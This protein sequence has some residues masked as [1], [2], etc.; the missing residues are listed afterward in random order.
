[1]KLTELSQRAYVPYSGKPEACV[2][3]SVEGEFFGGVRI[4]NVSFPLTIGAVQGAICHCLLAGQVPKTVFIEHD[5]YVP[6]F[7]REEFELEIQEADTEHSFS[8]YS[9][10]KTENVDI[11]QCLKEALPLAVVPNSEFRVSSYLES[12]EGYLVGANVEFSDWA[13]GLCAERLAISMAVTEGI[14]TFDRMELHT[15]KGNFSSPCGACRQVIYEFMPLHPIQFHH[16]DGTKSMHQ[17]VDLLPY[18]FRSN[19]LRKQI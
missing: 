10:L 16:A 7:F 1:M 17:T 13:H 12:P 9:Y 2:I 3:E 8:L 19:E 11:E 5:Q 14:T 6:P 4:E 15:E 18:S